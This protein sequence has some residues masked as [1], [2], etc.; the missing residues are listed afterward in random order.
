MANLQAGAS[1]VI[2]DLPGGGDFPAHRLRSM[3][4]LALG[5]NLGAR[6]TFLARARD[7]IEALPA[8]ILRASA[9]H[10]TPALLP[11]G[12]PRE[13]DVPYLNQMLAVV[14]DTQPLE[15]LRALKALERALGRVDRGR[16]GPRE[17][18]IDLLTYHDV[19]MDTPELALPHPGLAERR[20]VLAPL[21][22]IVPEWRYPGERRAC[23]EQR[24]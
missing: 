6:E 24:A 20:F 18:D 16:W 3:I 21:V 14:T 5:S 13:W 4:L 15:L 1:F 11:E 7:G 12:A 23:R 17:I 2:S 19:A 22:E 8:E 9:I 10:E